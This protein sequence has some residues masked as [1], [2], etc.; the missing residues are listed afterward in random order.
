MGLGAARAFFYFIQTFLHWQASSALQ[1]YLLCS[2]SFLH[3]LVCK[4]RTNPSASNL[5]SW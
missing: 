1:I 3:L 2:I 4:I 5:P